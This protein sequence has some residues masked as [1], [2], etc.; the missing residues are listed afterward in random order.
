MG[1]VYWITGL[2]GAGK[3]TVGN[4]LYD[5]LCRD[6][7]VVI[8]LDGDELR[9]IFEN[10]DYSYDGRKKLGYQY[11]KLCKCISDQGIDVVICTIAMFE[12][13]RRWNRRN[14]EEYMEIYLRVNKDELIRRDKKGIYSAVLNSKGKEVCGIDLQVELPENPDIIIDNYGDTTPD[15]ALNAIV[16]L[17]EEK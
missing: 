7:A 8:K 13:L 5:Y 6:N 11:S 17:V 3:T 4:L 16:Q 15:D 12:D 10:N 14:F 2:S 1:R 9:V